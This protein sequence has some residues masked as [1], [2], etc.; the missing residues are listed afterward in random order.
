MNRG[1]NSVVAT[2][3]TLVLLVDTV[4]LVV[5][6]DF[7]VVVKAVTAMVGNEVVLTAVFLGF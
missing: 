1:V 7:L 6:V 2:V 4:L 5:V 3:V